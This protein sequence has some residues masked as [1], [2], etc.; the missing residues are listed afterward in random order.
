MNMFAQLTEKITNNIVNFKDYVAAITTTTL[1]SAPISTITVST[2]TMS[3]TIINN[4][5]NIRFEDF[6]KLFVSD[7]R[8]K[9]S[10]NVKSKSSINRASKYKYNE[11]NNNNINSNL[12]RL[13]MIKPNMINVDDII[14]IN[15]NIIDNACDS[16]NDINNNIINAIVDAIIGDINIDT[17]IGTNINTNDYMNVNM[18]M[19]MNINIDM[20]NNI[21]NDIKINT[22]DVFSNKDNN[23]YMNK[24]LSPTSISFS[25]GGYNCVY[26]MG[27]I[28]YIFK[29]PELFQETKFLGASGGAG[30]IAILLCFENDPNR[31]KILREIIEFVISLKGRNLKLHKQVEEY[32]KTLLSYVT[33]ERF[34]KY[35]KNS[36]RCHISVTNITYFVPKNEIMTKFSSYEQF[37]DVLKATAS[38]P[39]LLDNKIRTIGTNKYID[40]GLSNNIPILDKTTLKISCLNYPTLNADLYPKYQCAIIHCFIAPDKNY[41]MNMHD[42]GLSD[43]ER[44]MKPNYIK[45][46]NLRKENEL[47]KCVTNIISSPEYPSNIIPDVT[48]DIIPDTIDIISDA[49]LDIMSDTIPNIMF[50]TTPNIMVDIV[51][52][53]TS[54]E[55]LELFSI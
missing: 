17:N 28:Q 31:Q 33:E 13:N 36:D 22:H 45:F 32:S 42:Q 38:V 7:L 54:N 2:G 30:I 34:N 24:K 8:S 18:N 55:L 20:D 14:S 40:G 19:N 47:N 49:T 44:Y 53:V 50:D 21:D 6:A 48:L 41:I 43:I 4:L 12:I 46:Q 5:K 25:G 51:S 9:S 39:I 1:S 16:D 15:N 52:D 10:F 27:V 3:R 23:T 35:I 11:R 37:M 29:N 26:H